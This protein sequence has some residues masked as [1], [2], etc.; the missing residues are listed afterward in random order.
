MVGVDFRLRR[1]E[2][3]RLEMLLSLAWQQ[4]FA[5]VV[6]VDLVTVGRLISRSST[7]SCTDDSRVVGVSSRLRP[8]DFR[9]IEMLLSLVRQQYFAHL[10]SQCCSCSLHEPQGAVQE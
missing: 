10:A 7:H 6:V 2:L 5:Q 8:D 4:H 1:A 9:I 3:R